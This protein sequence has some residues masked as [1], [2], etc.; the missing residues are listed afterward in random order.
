MSESPMKRCT[1]HCCRV[2]FLPYDYKTLLEHYDVWRAGRWS[3][4]DFDGPMPDD[5][6]VIALMVRP[7]S[8]SVAAKRSGLEMRDGANSYRCIHVQR[9]GDCGIY[10]RRPK[11]CSNYPYDEK[12][13]IKGCTARPKKFGVCVKSNGGDDGHTD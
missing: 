7:L 10:D 4:D 12:C 11:M 5:I 6:D 13:R 8:P 1:G 2:L 3:D 9:N